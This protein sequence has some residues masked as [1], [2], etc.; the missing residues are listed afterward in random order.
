[1]RNQAYNNAVGGGFAN[2]VAGLG[3]GMAPVAVAGFT[4]ITNN[5]SSRTALT[6]SCARLGANFVGNVSCGITALARGPEYI[7]LGR[8]PAYPL[9]GV[10]RILFQIGGGVMLLHQR[11]ATTAALNN[12]GLPPTSSADYRGLVY[13]IVT[14]PAGNIAVGF[15]HNLYTL[16]ANRVTVAAQIGNMLNRM[17]AASNGLPAVPLVARYMGGDFNVGFITPRGGAD[18]YSANAPF[19]PAGAAG[20]GTT[21]SGSL[22]DYWYSDIA[23]AAPPGLIVPVASASSITMDAG[24]GAGLAGLA[25]RMSDHTA[26]MLQII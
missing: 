13:I 14:T 1:M 15:L 9:V 19:Y 10:G 2:I 8:N 24:P 23:G 22:Y 5:R 25:Q 4:E 7:G 6:N 3:V 11:A 16:Q 20:M 12:L 26:T 21:Y 18:G 17:G